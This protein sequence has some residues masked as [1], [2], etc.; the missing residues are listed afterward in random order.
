MVWKNR[1]S[2][3]KGIA[4]TGAAAALGS[5]IAA[6]GEDKSPKDEIPDEIEDEFG[7]KLVS[8]KISWDECDAP[9]KDEHDAL[10]GDDGQG[11]WSWIL[12][13][14]GTVQFKA[15]T[16]HVEFS[17]GEKDS[18]QGDFPGVGNVAYFDVIRELSECNYAKITDAYVEYEALNEPCDLELTLTDS[19]CI[20]GVP[21]EPPTD[22]NGDDGHEKKCKKYQ[23]K[24]LAFHKL[25][26]K[27]YGKQLKHHRRKV[28]FHKKLYKKGKCE[29]DHDDG[30]DKKKK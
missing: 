22:G 5:S 25:R 6:A 15:A 10:S 17:D 4:G 24:K 2:I 29:V 30:D 28:R 13:G 26:K 19:V 11:Q 14:A 1:R 3:L 18:V 27:Y 7:D 20:D 23:A 9:G 21:Q 8:G 12:T 16:L